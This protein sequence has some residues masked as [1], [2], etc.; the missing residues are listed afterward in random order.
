MQTLILRPGDPWLIW[1]GMLSWHPLCTKTLAFLTFTLLCVPWGPKAGP[2]LNSPI[3]NL[4]MHSVQ[5]WFSAHAPIFGWRRPFWWLL[6]KAQIYEYKHK[7]ISVGILSVTFLTSFFCLST[8]VSTCL[9]FVY[10]SLLFFLLFQLCLVYVL[11]SI[12]F[13][14][15]KEM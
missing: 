13:L 15:I 2:Q 12:Q 8:C 1:N 7:R 6:A 10:L 9:C 11:P 3:W 5:L 4:T 14:A